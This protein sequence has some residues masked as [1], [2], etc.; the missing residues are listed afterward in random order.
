MFIIVNI[1]LA[2]ITWYLLFEKIC[3]S[4]MKN[5]SDPEREINSAPFTSKILN[6]FF[7]V[8]VSV[9][10]YLVQVGFASDVCH[11]FSNSVVEEQKRMVY[12]T[13]PTST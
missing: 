13:H 3:L 8:V 7:A 10:T 12:S 11:I 6:E 5:Y 9:E 4:F 2:S 1:S